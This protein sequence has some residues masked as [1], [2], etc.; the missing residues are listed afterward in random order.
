[1][2]NVTI[3]NDTITLVI[4]TKNTYW[5]IFCKGM[6]TDLCGIQQQMWRLQRAEANKFINSKHKKYLDKILKRALQESR[7]RK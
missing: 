4:Q 3:R 1:M 6:E 7:N 5:K 2:K